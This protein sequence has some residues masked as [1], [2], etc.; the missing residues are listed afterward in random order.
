MNTPL[1]HGELVRLAPIE[2]ESSPPVGARHHRPLDY[3]R[4]LPATPNYF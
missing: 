2:P 4:P 1:L 3:W